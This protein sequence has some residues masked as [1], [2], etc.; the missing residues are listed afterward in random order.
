MMQLRRDAAYIRATPLEQT[1]EAPLSAF[2]QQVLQLLST[3]HTVKSAAK[4]LSRPSDT[5]L[6]GLEDRIAQSMR[7][8]LQADRIQQ[9]PDS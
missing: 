3:A 1:S 7:R 4:A 9:S 2:D 5:S 6:E 8:L